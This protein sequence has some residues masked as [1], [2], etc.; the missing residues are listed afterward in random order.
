MWEIILNLQLFSFQ[1]NTNNYNWEV[2]L[3]N[4]VPKMFKALLLNAKTLN[5]DQ[6]CNETQ[7]MIFTDFGGK[8]VGIIVF[9]PGFLIMWTTI[10]AL[11]LILR[12]AKQD[13]SGL[14]LPTISSSEHLKL[15]W[16]KEKSA[17]WPILTFLTVAVTLNH[18]DTLQPVHIYVCCSVS[19]S[20]DC[21]FGAL[22]ATCNK[23]S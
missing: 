21:H 10:C 8:K 13:I 1:I 11:A 3:D 15:Q 20:C 14:H 9:W 19:G 4:L 23:Q 12:N 6:E 7:Y 18:L 17:I 16:Y 2:I 5:V 22:Q